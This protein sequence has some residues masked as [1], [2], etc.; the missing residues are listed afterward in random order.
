MNVKFHNDNQNEINNKTFDNSISKY[1]NQS[2]RKQ[3][4]ETNF[5]INYLNQIIVSHFNID[6]TLKDLN[7]LDNKNMLNDNSIDFYLQFLCQQNSNYYF[8]LPSTYFS[9]ME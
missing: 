2:K 1:N 5:S 6:L 9:K 7:T 8:S 4:G 3:T